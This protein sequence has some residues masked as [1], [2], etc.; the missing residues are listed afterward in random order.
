MMFDEYV[1]LVLYFI[2]VAHLDTGNPPSLEDIRAIVDTIEPDS[3]VFDLAV[4][5]LELNEIYVKDGFVFWQDC[6][7]R[8]IHEYEVTENTTQLYHYSNIG[9]ANSLS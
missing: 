1:E 3:S 8:A 5:I 9:V 2:T 7:I 6:T 4:A